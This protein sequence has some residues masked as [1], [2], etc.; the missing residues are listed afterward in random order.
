M[1]GNSDNKSRYNR[2]TAIQCLQKHYRPVGEIIEELQSRFNVSLV[3]QYSSHS[4]A[5][6]LTASTS[7]FH[8]LSARRRR[9]STPRRFRD[10]QRTSNTEGYD[11]LYCL[12]Y[13]LFSL[14]F[15]VNKVM[16]VKSFHRSRTI[17]PNTQKF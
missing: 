17:A 13:F 12:H 15:T 2:C 5:S 9:I 10:S 11:K 16:Y 3:V 14:P 6:P 1:P 8:V 7:A 4:S